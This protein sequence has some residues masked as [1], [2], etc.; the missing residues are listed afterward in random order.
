MGIQ[1]G[2]AFLWETTILDLSARRCA[3]S[4]YLQGGDS[5]LF[6]TPAGSA[7]GRT[8]Y[9]VITSVTRGDSN[10]DDG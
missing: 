1:I 7:F 6:M 2:K 10:I 4:V 5:N 8:T 9:W 3:I